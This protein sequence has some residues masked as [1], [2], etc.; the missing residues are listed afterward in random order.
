MLRMVGDAWSSLFPAFDGLRLADVEAGLRL[1][2][3]EL[4]P[5]AFSSLIDQAAEW[6]LTER[7]HRFQFPLYRFLGM[8]AEV[9]RSGDAE[10]RRQATLPF[11]EREVAAA[12]ARSRETASR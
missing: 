11:A 7:F 4:E 5:E 3:S 1:A 10:R 9:D 8:L 6:V 2:K 12:S